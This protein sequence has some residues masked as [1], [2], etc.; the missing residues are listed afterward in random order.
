[1]TRKLRNL[2][3]RDQFGR[4]WLMENTWCDHCNVANLG[5]DKPCEYED[6]GH[7]FIERICRGC[8]NLVKS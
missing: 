1:M 2:S 5:I 6:D 3:A 7:V 8:G 4:D